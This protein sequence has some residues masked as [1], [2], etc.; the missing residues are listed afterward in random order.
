MQVLTIVFVSEMRFRTLAFHR[1]HV[2][3]LANCIVK[4]DLKT[5]VCLKI[6]HKPLINI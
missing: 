2:K 3:R 5:R 4:N 6:G 1:A